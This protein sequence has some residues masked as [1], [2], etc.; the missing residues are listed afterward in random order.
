MNVISAALFI[1]IL[2]ERPERLYSALQIGRLYAPDV[3]KDW[4]QRN[5][6]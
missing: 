3:G 5:G 1:S 4:M 6:A 2:A